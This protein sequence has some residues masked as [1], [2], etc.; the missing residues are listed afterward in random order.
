MASGNA[1][2]YNRPLSLTVN[3][4]WDVWVE[5]TKYSVTSRY[6]F[7]SRRVWSTRFGGS[8]DHRAEVIAF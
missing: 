6:S 1:D 3:D 5:R 4:L 8:H 7:K 2:K